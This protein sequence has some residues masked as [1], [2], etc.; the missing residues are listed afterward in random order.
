MKRLCKALSLLSGLTLAAAP[1]W[2]QTTAP[3]TT[4]PVL[5]LGQGSVATRPAS[6]E[7]AFTLN[8]KKFTEGD[9]E[10]TFRQLMGGGQ[11]QMDESQMARLMQASRRQLIDAMIR[12]ELLRGEAEKHKIS[13]TDADLEANAEKL[14]QRTLK[15]R[16]MSRE[17]LDQE[18]KRQGN[19]TLD[20]QMK[21]IK[22][23]PRFYK[24]VLQEKLGQAMFKNLEVSEE[25]IQKRHQQDRRYAAQVQASHILIRADASEAP[26]K[27]EEARKKAEEVLAEVKKPGAD[28]AELARKYSDC[29]SKSRGGD[30]G[31]FPRQGAMVEPFAAAAFALKPGE[32]SGV[33]ETNFGYHIIKTTDTRPAKDL[34]AV[35]E[36]IKDEVRAS[37]VQFELQKRLQELRAEAKVEYPPG[38]EPATQ[39]ALGRSR[40]PAPTGGRAATQPVS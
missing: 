24:H 29:P 3:A 33:V 28:F 17:Q 8:G 31:F 27:R 5:R 12:D 2:A 20:E 18:I 35:R 10:K 6:D 40:P 23:D 37:K 19:I 1:A 4:R 34:D 38:K 25:E 36:E 30:L 21:R 16:S 11:L 9:L 13:V 32:I 22:E 15:E 7:V 26:E 39:P 14:L